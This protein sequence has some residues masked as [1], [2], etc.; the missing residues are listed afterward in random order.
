ML[1]GQELGLGP[2][3]EVE[4]VGMRHFQELDVVKS[5]KEKGRNIPFKVVLCK[6]KKLNCYLI[7]A[8]DFLT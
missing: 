1:K 2:L 6:T 5:E 8:V 4:V 7:A 3:H